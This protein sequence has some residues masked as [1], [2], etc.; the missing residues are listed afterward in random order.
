MVLG[1]GTLGSQSEAEL[2]P[3]LEETCQVMEQS[4]G[5]LLPGGQQVS[6]ASAVNTAASH[7]H[8]GPHR[9]CARLSLRPL[10][11]QPCLDSGSQF[12]D[13]LP[14][15]SCSLD[16]LSLYCP[17]SQALAIPQDHSCAQTLLTPDSMVPLS[18]DSPW[19]GHQG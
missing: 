12:S 17:D 7:E 11:Q 6:L 19:K 4:G 2:S 8:S 9:A 14:T 15:V 3:L 18:A 5:N 10:A 16:R 1:W 13:S